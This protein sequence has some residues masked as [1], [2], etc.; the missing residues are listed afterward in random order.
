MADIGV[1]F[2][3]QAHATWLI[4]NTSVSNVSQGA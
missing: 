3:C 2:S 1:E 4:V